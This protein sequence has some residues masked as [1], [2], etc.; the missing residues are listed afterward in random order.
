MGN[1]DLF[2]Q[3]MARIRNPQKSRKW[4]TVIFGWTVNAAT[5]N[6]WML[7]RFHANELG[8]KASEI[9]TLVEYSLA[10]YKKLI[11]SSK[12]FL[13]L[14]DSSFTKTRSGKQLQLDS[15]ALDVSGSSTQDRLRCGCCSVIDISDC[16]DEVMVRTGL[17]AAAKESMSITCPVAMVHLDQQLSWNMLL[18]ENCHKMS[19]LQLMEAGFC[20][21]DNCFSQFVIQTWFQFRRTEINCLEINNHFCLHLGV[22]CHYA[23]PVHTDTISDLSGYNESKNRDSS[24]HSLLPHFHLI[25]CNSPPILYRS[26]AQSSL[27]GGREFLRESTENDRNQGLSK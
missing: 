10:I 21:L 27:S 3:H 9:S 15:S 6:A 7:Y 18:G 4:P 17:P 12:N 23:A 20:S 14:D 16:T 19:S 22:A 5:I 25:K 11:S 1:V 13:E 2:D 26:A 24:L 8:K